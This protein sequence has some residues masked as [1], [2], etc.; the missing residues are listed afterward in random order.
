MLIPS[1]ENPYAYENTEQIRSPLE[2]WYKKQK[3]GQTKNSSKTDKNKQKP[4]MCNIL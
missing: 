1:I 3:N 2:E 4:T